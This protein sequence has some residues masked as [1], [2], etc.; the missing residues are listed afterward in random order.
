[1]K[2][3]KPKPTSKEIMEEIN[4]LGRL[5]MQN[6]SITKN[7]IGLLERYIEYK[8]D[9]KEFTELVKTESEERKKTSVKD[10]LDSQSSSKKEEPEKAKVA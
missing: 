9:T 5:T 7:V 6:G 2:N 4:Y 1:M 10:I 8:G 3:K